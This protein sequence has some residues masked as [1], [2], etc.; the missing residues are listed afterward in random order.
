[1]YNISMKMS[2][3]HLLLFLVSTLSAC[4]NGFVVTWGNSLNGGDSSSGD[5]SSDVS[6][7]YSTDF[8]FAALK[9]NGSVVTWG[10]SNF[11]GDSSNVMEDLSSD[12]STIYSTDYAFAALKN[13]GSVV[14]WGYSSW[15]GNSSSVD[16]SS[17]V[18]TIYSN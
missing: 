10:S 17:D 7:I 13:D 5:V 18:S 3:L 12:V 11:G 14:T 4:G 2:Y 8:A 9:N 1:M 6:T 16:L 15:G